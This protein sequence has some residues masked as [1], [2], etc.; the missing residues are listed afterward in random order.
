MEGKNRRL[1]ESLRTMEAQQHA[2][3]KEMCELDSSLRRKSLE[4]EQLQAEVARLQ[5]TVAKASGTVTQANRLI[6]CICAFQNK[7]NLLKSEV[8]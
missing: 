3:E 8:R 2:V 6:F 5:S 7:S 1:S 4:N